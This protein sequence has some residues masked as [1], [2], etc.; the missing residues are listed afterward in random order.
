MKNC[1]HKNKSK[2]YKWANGI[3]KHYWVQ[4]CE[5]CDKQLKFEKLT[6]MEVKK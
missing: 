4:Y 5:D 2:V 3:G 6:E 1:K